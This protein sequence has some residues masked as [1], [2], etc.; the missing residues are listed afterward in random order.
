ME[1]LKVNFYN[2]GFKLNI[3]EGFFEISVENA[4][5]ATK[6]LNIDEIFDA[7]NN[8]NSC[9]SGYIYSEKE[10]KEKVIDEYPEQ[11]EN[12]LHEFFN[13]KSDSNQYLTAEQQEEMEAEFSHFIYKYNK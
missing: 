5:N 6:R 2:K 9:V 13:Q 7:I 12:L 11:F 1:L 8:A 3:E 10:I 4:K